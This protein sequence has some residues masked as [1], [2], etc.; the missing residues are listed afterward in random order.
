MRNLF[1]L[2]RWLTLPDAANHLT[3]VL[4]QEVS[5][6][7]ILRLA[8]DNRL[9]LSVVFVGSVLASLCK[10]VE[11]SGV[12]YNE[13]PTL[14]GDGILRL[15]IGGQII[16][17]ANGGLLQS[18]E[19]VFHL[20]ND[21]PY[22]LTMMGGERGD[23][24]YRYWTLAG[25]PQIETTNLNGTFVSSGKT[26]YQLKAKLPRKKG[27]EPCFYPIGG[28]PVDTALVV[29]HDALLSL[30]KF[31]A[32][33]DQIEEKPLATTERNTLLTIIAVLA[34]AAK[35]QIDDYSKPGKAAGYIEG[36]TDEFGAH[37]SKRA[38]EDHLKKIPDALRTRMK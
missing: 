15:P 7:D 13:V 35:V 33:S 2:K 23:I 19:K 30:E 38:I 32:E 36:L 12:E 8:L 31:I 27:E 4:R 25:G 26:V 5:E 22:S 14:S 16:T 10:P 37:V 11:Y 6:A 21:E 9:E 20:E 18:Q 34:K 28:L 1:K 29:T 3:T 24:E 17:E